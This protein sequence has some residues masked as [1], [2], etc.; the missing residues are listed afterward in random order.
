MQASKLTA[1]D[2]RA[3]ATRPGLVPARNVMN[4]FLAGVTLVQPSSTARNGFQRFRF[5]LDEHRG[6]SVLMSSLQE[7]RK[8]EYGYGIT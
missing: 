2:T 7:A 1:M 4:A 5:G 6:R 8:V 3:L